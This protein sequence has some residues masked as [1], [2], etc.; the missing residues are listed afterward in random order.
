MDEDLRDKLEEDSHGSSY[1]YRCNRR[2]NPASLYCQMCRGDEKTAEDRNREE[3]T[4]E[5][6]D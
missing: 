4:A 3:A 5:E 6:E 1:C 2:Y